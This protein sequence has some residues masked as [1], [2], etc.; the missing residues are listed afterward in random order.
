MYNLFF[1]TYTNILSNFKNLI[2]KIVL[3]ESNRKQKIQFLNHV[4]LLTPITTFC[5]RVIPDDNPCL[6]ST[7]MMFSNM[8][9]LAILLINILQQQSQVL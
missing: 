2:K 4:E 7:E 6:L 9:E 5:L 3:S 8:M 1:K